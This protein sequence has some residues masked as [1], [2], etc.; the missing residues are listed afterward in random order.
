M[1]VYAS[2]YL[3]ISDDRRA[4]MICQLD[5]IFTARPKGGAQG[6]AQ[7]GAESQGAVETTWDSPKDVAV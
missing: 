4:P 3:C 2:L 6:G 1:C 5:P 7:G